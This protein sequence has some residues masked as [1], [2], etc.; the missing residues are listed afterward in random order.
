[1]ASKKSQSFDVELLKSIVDI[2][3]QSGVAEMEISTRNFKVRLSKYASPGAAPPPQP[4]AP[5]PIAEAAPPESEDTEEGIH[6]IRAPMV[7]TFYR[8]PAPGADPFVKEG[9]R[10]RKGDVVCII[11][12]MKIMNEIKSDVDGV[13]EEV[14]VENAHPVE[15]GQP[16]FK[17]RL[18]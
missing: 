17:V 7:G 11:E 8:A 18:V 14:L 12:A 4:A 9:D 2:F 3:T 1:M 6:Y 13:I 16:L 10:V 15:Y 5:Q